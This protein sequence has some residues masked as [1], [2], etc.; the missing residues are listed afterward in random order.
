[1]MIICHTHIYTHYIISIWNIDTVQ[2]S[3]IC[4]C[5]HQ[6]FLLPLFW[7]SH[8]QA[9]DALGIGKSTQA[10]GVLRTLQQFVSGLNTSHSR[11]RE[12]REF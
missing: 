11:S 2:S 6:P 3:H 10:T 1:M 9:L 12:S 5:G 8:C 4:V 7:R